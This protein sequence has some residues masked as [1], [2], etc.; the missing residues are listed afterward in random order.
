MLKLWTY[1]ALWAFSHSGTCWTRASSA[2]SG[3]GR[4]R[5]AGMRKTFVVWKPWFRGV[6]TVKS[7][8]TAAQEERT[9]KAAHCPADAWTCARS[10]VATPAASAITTPQYSHARGVS[11]RTG[12][13]EPRPPIAPLSVTALI[14]RSPGPERPPSS[15]VRPQTAVH[16]THPVPARHP[17]FA[18]S[19]APSLGQ[20]PGRRSEVRIGQ[21]RR[22][23]GRAHEVGA[24]RRA[25]VALRR[26]RPGRVLDRGVRPGHVRP[27]HIAPRD[28]RPARIRPRHVAPGRIRPGHVRPR[29]V[30]P[31]H[32]RPCHRVPGRVALDRVL[33]A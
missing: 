14:V 24:R 20:G 10:G 27:G 3:A 16:G 11:S 4:S 26:I 23:V 5:I 33:P 2:T 19:R 1:Q 17:P 28:V 21:D 12:G 18:G 13:L 30:T 31:G 9:A 15:P 29:C 22:P 8:A 32:V 7:W 6:W 25:R